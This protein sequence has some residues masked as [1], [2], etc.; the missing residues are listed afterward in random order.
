M[1]QINK[2]VLTLVAIV[3]FSVAVNSMDPRHYPYQNCQ[4]Q[5]GGELGGHC[6]CPY[7]HP[8]NGVYC[9]DGGRCQ[10]Y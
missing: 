1:T 4:C 2:I 9:K 3:M 6:H 7:D 8:M 10:N 5:C